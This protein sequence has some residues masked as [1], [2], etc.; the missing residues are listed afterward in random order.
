MSIG[1]FPI[2][3]P[4][5]MHLHAMHVP[6]LAILLLPLQQII[7]THSTQC[8]NSFI[9]GPNRIT[10]IYSNNEILFSYDYHTDLPTWHTMS[11]A[12]GVLLMLASSFCPNRIQDADLLLPSNLMIAQGELLHAHYHFGHINFTKL[13]QWAKHGYMV[14]NPTL[15]DVAH[16]FVLHAFIAPCKSNCIMLLLK[17]SQNS[18]HLPSD[19]VSVDQMV[20]GISGHIPFQAG[21][22]SKVS[23]NT[24]PFGWITTASS[25]WTYQDTPTTKEMLQ[26]GEAFKNFAKWN[27]VWI[28]HIWSINGIFASA[29]LGKHINTH[30]Q[31]HTLC[32]VS[33]HW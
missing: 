3:K 22:V 23:T 9:G 7:S 25:L 24:V 5:T 8:S 6:G 19:L 10:L 2:S 17:H 33:T 26:F 18:A 29:Y 11:G 14:F 31:C 28:K 21:Q 12:H 20:S 16:H 4:V 1:H 30:V 27:D 13:Q 32:S 15:Q